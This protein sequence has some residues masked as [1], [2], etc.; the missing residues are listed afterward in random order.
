MG[1]R[2]GFPPA[3][4]MAYSGSELQLSTDT[5]CGRVTGGPPRRPAA[6]LAVLQAG[7]RHP[8]MIRR[9]RKERGSGTVEV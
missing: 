8:E 3:S 5:A 7:G 9:L 6:P 2:S 4:W 1:G